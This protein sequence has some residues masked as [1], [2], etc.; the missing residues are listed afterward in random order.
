MPAIR[1]KVVGVVIFLQY[2]WN[3]TT[4]EEDAAVVIAV[5]VG[6]SSVKP[7]SLVVCQ[8]SG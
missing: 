7:R 4:G 2:Y 3:T 8:S 1:Q 5:A 6:C